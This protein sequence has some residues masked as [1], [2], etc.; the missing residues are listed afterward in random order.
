MK[1]VVSPNYEHVKW[2]AQWKEAFPEATL[3]GQRRPYHIHQPAFQ[4]LHS[5]LRKKPS[6]SWR[7]VY[8]YNRQSSEKHNALP[9]KVYINQCEYL[10][11]AP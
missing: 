2:A 9:A 10:G 7:I 4:S 5:C 6:L 11:Y 3:Y 8:E 1:H